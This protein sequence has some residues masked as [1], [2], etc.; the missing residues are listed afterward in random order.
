M[1]K[2][3]LI[4]AIAGLFSGFFGVGGGFIMVPLLAGLARFDQHRSHATS[5][6]AIILISIAAVVRF[7]IGGE[8]D[9]VA[10][11]VLGAG[12]MIGSTLG[13]NWMNRIPARTLRVIF[14]VILI[15]AGITLAI[16][17]EP[18]VGMQ[19]QR[20]LAV[21]IGLLIGMVAGIAS[22]LAGIGGGVVMVP[23]MVFFLGM[24]QHSAEG[25]SLLA[26]G[27]TALAGTRVN[28]KHGRVRLI[29]A[30]VMAVAGVVCSP[31]GASLA[32]R[33]SGANLSRLFGVFVLVIGAR[34]LYATVRAQRS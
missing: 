30:A 24:S 19:P 27:F 20:P 26:I 6:A 14:I 13:A 1:W 12:G 7:G 10:G 21:L 22:G 23:A 25:T 16:G 32:L 3:L 29:D 4:G 34:M 18:S 8:V 31:I 2:L 9:P 17:G 33:L 28:L 5:L 11:L 15:V